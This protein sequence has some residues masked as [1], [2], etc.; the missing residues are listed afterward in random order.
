MSAFTQRVLLFHGAFR[1][2]ELGAAEIKGMG[3]IGMAFLLVK[4]WRDGKPHACVFRIGARAPKRMVSG[5]RR[6]LTGSP[7]ENRDARLDVHEL[8]QNKPR[9]RDADTEYPGE[10]PHE[11][12]ALFRT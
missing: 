2:T 11:P 10:K 7:F 6:R 3:N 1:G 12:V 9:E 5:E 4:K 8:E